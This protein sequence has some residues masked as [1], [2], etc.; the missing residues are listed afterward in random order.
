MS[1]KN[2]WSAIEIAN[3]ICLL[4]FTDEA[5]SNGCGVLVHCEAG[6][7]RSPTITIGYLMY[8]QSISLQEAYSLVKSR[9]DF[10]S[11]NL[12]FMG[13]LVELEKK[14]RSPVLNCK[15]PAL[16][17]PSTVQFE[18]TTETTE[19][20]VNQADQL[21]EL[22][23]STALTT[24]AISPN[25]S[26]FS[27]NISYKS[28]DPLTPPA[29]TRTLSV[30]ATETKE[31][32]TIKSDSH[33]FVA[34]LQAIVSTPVVPVTQLLQQSPT[35]TNTRTN[36]TATAA[37][38]SLPLGAVATSSVFNSAK[39]TT[40]TSPPVVSNLSLISSTQAF[41][42]AASSQSP[43]F[44]PLPKKITIVKQHQ[45]IGKSLSIS[46][47]VCLP[48][49]PPSSP[50]LDNL[51]TLSSSETLPA[52]PAGTTLSLN[53]ISPPITPPVKLN[54]PCS[55]RITPWPSLQKTTTPA[56][57]PPASTTSMSLTANTPIS[58]SAKFGFHSSIPITSI[59][60]TPTPNGGYPL[61][62]DLEQ[63]LK[64]RKLTTGGSIS[65]GISLSGPD[66]QFTLYRPKK[67]KNMTVQ[68]Q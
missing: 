25:N 19:L 43:A 58:P 36:S 11:P 37:T 68:V 62:L 59:P 12:N 27:E 35:T 41:V 5:R 45:P 31:K 46:L 56:L 39:T 61:D 9:R 22:A 1:P 38:I 15:L 8:R 17:G 66:F 47:P 7:S 33:S 14:L 65:S 30:Q 48:P 18:Q 13:Q 53:L 3:I 40:T 6:I 60:V 52:L 50:K 49:S 20:T 64:R 63:L 54:R 42:V 44:R 26:N 28:I 4:L 32:K 57:S 51:A 29:S 21:T 2:D 34:S 55:L 10:I 23:S 16:S 24:N 67:L